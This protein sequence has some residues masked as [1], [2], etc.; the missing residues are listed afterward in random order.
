MLPF[1]EREN[2]LERQRLCEATVESLTDD[3]G[4]KSLDINR[5]MPHDLK[6]RLTINN[7]TCTNEDGL[8]VLENVSFEAFGGEVL[9][10]AGISG[11][12]QKELLE[13]IAGLKV[14]YQ[15]CHFPLHS[16]EKILTCQHRD[17][18]QINELGVRHSFVPEDRLGMGLVGSMG[19]TG[20]MSL[21]FSKG[22]RLLYQLK[23][24]E[25]TCRK[26]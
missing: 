26:D 18:A 10:V 17:A 24:T 1:L 22:K 12:G 19:M 2:I 7:I 16:E 3:G 25:G 13:A 5:P 9:G 8:H 23:S 14:F 20:N 11:S 4:R 6:K 21:F 15:K